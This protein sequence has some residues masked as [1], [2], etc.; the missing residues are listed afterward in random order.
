MPV[1]TQKTMLRDLARDRE[2]RK[3]ARSA[4]PRHTARSHGERSAHQA[5][6]GSFKICCSRRNAAARHPAWSQAS[7][8][9]PSVPTSE[10][11]RQLDMA[12]LPGVPQCVRPPE[13]RQGGPR[14]RDGHV[15]RPSSA[16]GPTDRRPRTRIRPPAM[17][18]SPDQAARLGVSQVVLG[19]LEPRAGQPKLVGRERQCLQQ[20]AGS[21]KVV[22]GSLVQQ[23][24]LEQSPQA[25]VHALGNLS[26]RSWRYGCSMVR[27]R[28]RCCPRVSWARR[29]LC[30]EPLGSAETVSSDAR[31]HRQ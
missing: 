24:L 11:I 25:L 10:R 4:A 20:A 23:T 19:I 5:G 26:R 17:P 16:L 13:T 29:R 9:S 30:A 12:W 15:S 18:A 3:V 8:R 14:C 7:R 2:L 28:K 31:A 22:V 27:P 6:F 1:D 21:R